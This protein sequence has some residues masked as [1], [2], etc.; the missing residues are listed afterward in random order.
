MACC[1]FVTRS[2]TASS[3]GFASSTATAAASCGSGTSTSPAPV[4]HVASST[5]V[6]HETTSALGERGECAASPASERS[7]QEGTERRRSTT[8]SVGPLSSSADTRTEK[9]A[10]DEADVEEE[11]T[12]AAAETDGE[13]DDPAA[14][15]SRSML[16]R[17]AVAQ[18]SSS[19]RVCESVSGA[20]APPAPT[21]PG[22][23][24]A[25][26]VQQRVQSVNSEKG[27]G[28]MNAQMGSASPSPRLHHRRANVFRGS[29]PQDWCH[30]ITLRSTVSR[31]TADFSRAPSRGA[32]SCGGIM[33]SYSL[34][35][36]SAL[37]CAS[38]TCARRVRL[39]PTRSS[40]NRTVRLPPPP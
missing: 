31:S 12:A 4:R 28:Q 29:T 30:E 7:A 15:F 6:S 5:A 34:T 20:G 2:S 14:A 38:P 22:D 27:V 17:S 25:P 40:D 18:H 26:P 16:A 33:R 35:Q 19:A 11:E 1:A 9:C 36:R 21:S 8:R 37:E 10:A 24:Q 39:R 3:T 23:W 32:H 13:A